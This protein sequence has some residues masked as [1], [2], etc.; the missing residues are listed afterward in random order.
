MFTNNLM[1][2]GLCIPVT[3]RSYSIGSY[4]ENSTLYLSNRKHSPKHQPFC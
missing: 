2:K 3:W 1:K 4:D